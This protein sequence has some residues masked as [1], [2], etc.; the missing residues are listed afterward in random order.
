MKINHP[1]QQG[2]TLI[3]ILVVVAIMAI[4]TVL[5]VPSMQTFLENSQV[6]SASNTMLSGLIYA[7]NEA[8]KLGHD[9]VLCI[10]NAS[11]T[12]CSNSNRGYANGYIVFGDKPNGGNAGNGILD[13]TERVLLYQEALPTGYTLTSN[14]SPT[15]SSIRYSATGEIKGAS[16]FTLRLSKNGTLKRRLVFASTGRVRIAEP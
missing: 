10:S 6:R 14:K 5:A 1:P 8:T 12:A 9:V 15:S 2:F 13:S 16:G 3:E 7:R 4:V 11:G